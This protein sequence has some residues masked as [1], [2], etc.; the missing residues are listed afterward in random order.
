MYYMYKNNWRTFILLLS[1][2]VVSFDV[3]LIY[4]RIC[5]Y[6]CTRTC[7]SFLLFHSLTRRI[8]EN[9]NCILICGINSQGAGSTGALSVV[10]DLLPAGSLNVR[11]PGSCRSTVSDTEYENVSIF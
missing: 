5:M 10:S 2:C 11:M 7:P 6:V 1:L 9:W 3:L 8:N 4:K